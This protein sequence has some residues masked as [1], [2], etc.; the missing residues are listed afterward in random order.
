MT[1]ERETNLYCFAI[2][3]E[4]GQARADPGFENA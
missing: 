2:S 3:D 1:I 4:P